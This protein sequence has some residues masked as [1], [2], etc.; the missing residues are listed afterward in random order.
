LPYLVPKGE[1]PA[2]STERR[3]RELCEKGI[4]SACF[5]SGKLADQPKPAFWNRDG[6]V[7]PA[8]RQGFER[9]MR[10]CAL[11]HEMGCSFAVSRLTTEKDMPDAAEAPLR[12][13]RW[14][15][16]LCERRAGACPTLAALLEDDGPIHRPDLAQALRER[17]CARKDDFTW[18]PRLC[19]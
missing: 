3:L 10:A 17:G 8:T 12:L 5:L 9:Y 6:T 14:I 2:K 13:V 18:A 7:R 4:G 11:G 1:D 15:E 19:K 16:R